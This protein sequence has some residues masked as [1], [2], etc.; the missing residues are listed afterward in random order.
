MASGKQ[1]TCQCR[2]H[3]FHPWSRRSHMP[4]SNKAQVPCCWAC[5]LEPGATAAELTC[6]SYCSP[7][8]RE[9]TLHNGRSHPN[10]KP[11][12]CDLR[13]AA[14]HHIQRKAHVTVNTRHSHEEIKFRKY[15]VRDW[16]VLMSQ[17]DTQMLHMFCLNFTALK[18]FT[19]LQDISHTKLYFLLLFKNMTD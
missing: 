3:R 6:R 17:V 13:A 4:W 7:R 15:K 11:A 12:H 14:V 1:F 5:A 2:R 9:P 18:M 10:E 16:P 8:F 19:L